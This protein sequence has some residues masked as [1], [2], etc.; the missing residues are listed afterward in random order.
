MLS[1]VPTF[2]QPATIAP[3]DYAEELER[4]TRD[5]RQYVVD[6]LEQWKI[7]DFIREELSWI[8]GIGDQVE[9][10]I[11]AT[12]SDGRREKATFVPGV[13]NGAAKSVPDE[14]RD[15]EVPSPLDIQVALS[16]FPILE[17]SAMSGSFDTRPLETHLAQILHDSSGQI[18]ETVRGDLVP[19]GI[20]EELLEPKIVHDTYPSSYFGDRGNHWPTRIFDSEALTNGSHPLDNILRVKLFEEI[21]IARR[22]KKLKDVERQR[23]NDYLQVC[24]GKEWQ[25]QQLQ[26]GQ[27]A[28][29]IEKGV[30]THFDLD[31]GEAYYDK[32]YGTASF[33][34]G[35]LRTVQ[36]FVS[37]AMLSVLMHG[38]DAKAQRAYGMLRKLP[39]PTAEKLRYLLDGGFIEMDKNAQV[40]RLIENYYFFLQQYHQSEWLHTLG[41][42]GNNI[43]ASDAASRAEVRE[44]LTDLSNDAPAIKAIL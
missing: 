29:S 35:P 14:M 42:N 43:F 34:Y 32:N 4:H 37:A 27:Q 20:F 12:G 38:K 24:K 16:A 21:Q 6:F 30:L 1:N 26:P 5:S 31:R 39:R 3:S 8:K 25:G 13:L 28:L 19:T 15:R 44:R 10:A 11:L 36:M 33:K 17:A 18:L 22:G 41:T 2:R 40:E 23:A 7:V 9:V